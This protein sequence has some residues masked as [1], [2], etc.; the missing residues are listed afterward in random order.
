[1]SITNETTISN[2]STQSIYIIRVNNDKN[3][4]K[5]KISDGE[6]KKKR[7]V[8]CRKQQQKDD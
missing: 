5:N 4:N 2:P 7:H 3:K 6:K 1:M 8:K